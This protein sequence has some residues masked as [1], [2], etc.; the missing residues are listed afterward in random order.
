MQNLVAEVRDL[1]L[2]KD[3]GTFKVN[4]TSDLPPHGVRFLRV[5]V[6]ASDKTVLPPA[7]AR[8]G[9]KAAKKKQKKE[10]MHPLGFEITPIQRGIPPASAMANPPSDS[11]S[12]AS[13]PHDSHGTQKVSSVHGNW[14]VWAMVLVAENVLPLLFVML[15]YRLKRTV[16]GNSRAM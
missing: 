4:F 6:R 2:E 15:R 9:Q 8:S 10:H 5:N 7:A 13:A 16:R 14:S 3:L 11:A 1:W 12:P